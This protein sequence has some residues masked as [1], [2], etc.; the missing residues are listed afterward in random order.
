MPKCRPKGSQRRSASSKGCS[1]TEEG[2]PV[3]MGCACGE[4][5]MSPIYNAVMHEDPVT[6]CGAGVMQMNKSA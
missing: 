3:R 2:P 4:W 5:G 1:G 6:Q